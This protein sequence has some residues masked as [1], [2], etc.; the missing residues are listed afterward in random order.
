MAAADKRIALVLGSGGARGL[1]HIGVIEELQAR[2][3]AIEA[4]AGCSMGALV[5]GIFCAGRLPE[6]RQWACSLTRREVFGLVDFAFGHPGFIKGDR[7]MAVLRGLTGEHL[8][9]ALPVPFTAVATDLDARRE[10]RIGH[11]PLFDAIRAS[12][13][14]PML[15]TPHRY[16]DRDL[17]DGG[18]LA[19]LPLAAG[20]AFGLPR[21]FAVDL[22]AERTAIA[23]PALPAMQPVAAPLPSN[24]TLRAIQQG[25][26]RL[27][28][29][30]RPA[31]A[32]GSNRGLMDL[33]SQ[34]LGAMHGFMTQMQLERYPP[35]LLIGIPENACA[36]YEFWRAEEMIALG[37]RIAGEALDQFEAG[38]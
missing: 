22:N 19:P 8:I 3:Y 18:L 20:K 12:I 15:L 26:A 36:I 13:A 2:G 9:E 4:V 35:D 24:D 30:V 7:V 38:S 33:M 25:W 28:Q 17:V 21:L 23:P 14:I 6:Y 27:L 37:R 1:A 31:V 34:S 11:G 5:G 32:N 29:G 16:L 10:I